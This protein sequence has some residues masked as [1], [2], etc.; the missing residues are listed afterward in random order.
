MILAHLDVGGKKLENLSHAPSTKQQPWLKTLANLLPLWLF[1]LAI[2]VEGF[3]RPPI[4]AWLGL[5]FFILAIVA[6]VGLLIMRWMPPMLTLI[7]LFPFLLLPAFDEIS[8]TYK[9]PFILTCAL[10]LSAGMIVYQHS[11]SALFRWVILLVSIGVTLI[12]A[13]NAAEN[14]WQMAG[15]LG[16]FECFPDYTGCPAL[17]G[18]ETPW[19]QLF[20]FF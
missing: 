11:R 14:F 15:D 6:G 2:T 8:T 4:P 20:F 7:S 1:S 18:Q 19:W 16:Y 5:V 17:T 3:P 12:F 13:W 10:L 9:T